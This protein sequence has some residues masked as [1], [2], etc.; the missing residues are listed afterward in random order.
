MKEF[1]NIEEIAKYYNENTKTYE[2]IEN[3][4]RFDVKFNF[5][6]NVNSNIEADNIKAYN[7]NANN[8]N[9][10][11]INANDINANDINAGDI[12]ARDIN[13]NDINYYALCMAYNTFKCHSVKGIRNNSK[14][15]CLDNE[16]EYKTAKET[17]NIDGK[18]YEITEELKNILKE[19]KE[20]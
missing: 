12:N 2:F 18:N 19:L 1:N 3:G 14:H 17:I 20:I 9:S 10:N 8:I 6:L 4:Y 16:I 11:N 7:I 15:F 13:A 5:N